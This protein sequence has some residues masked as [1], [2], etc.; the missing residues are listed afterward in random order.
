[1]ADDEIESLA[2]VQPEVFVELRRS[3]ALNVAY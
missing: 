1:V 3:F 2:S